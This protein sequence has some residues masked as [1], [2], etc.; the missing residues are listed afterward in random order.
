MTSFDPCKTRKRD[1]KIRREM[2]NI[3]PKLTLTM[4]NAS[5]QN[6]LK[7][8]YWF[9]KFWITFMF[10]N[11]WIKM[12]SWIRF[13]RPGKYK[14]MRVFKMRCYRPIILGHGLWLIGLGARYK[15]QPS[16]LKCEL[17]RALALNCLVGFSKW[18]LCKFWTTVNFIDELNCVLHCFKASYFI[19][20]LRYWVKILI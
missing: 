4:S 14:L 19:S 3:W 20:I 1:R 9:G 2:A 18:Y 6:K 10:V 11:P 8:Q 12:G 17:I 5:L 13:F 16:E 15:W 7:L